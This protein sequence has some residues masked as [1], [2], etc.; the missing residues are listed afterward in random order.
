MDRKLVIILVLLLISG[1]ALSIAAWAFGVFPFDLKVAFALRGE[2]NPAFAAVMTAVSFLGDGWMPVLLVFAVTAVC[3]YKRKWVEA[4]FV[5]ATLTSGILAG[6]L[7]MLVG[8]QRPPSFTMNPSDIFQ[9]F[10]Q[11][12]YPSGHVLFFVVFFGFVAYLAWKF[13]AGWMRWITISVCAILIVLIGPSRIYLG[14]HWVSDV[15]GSYIIGTFWLII[16]VLL[17]Q[18]VLY[19]RSGRLEKGQDL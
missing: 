6:V 17:Y 7:K 15:I 13:F 8:R 3:A 10:N 16:L 14:E 18:L 2:D 5:I 12:A 9:S 1:I 11:Y 19:R 4:A